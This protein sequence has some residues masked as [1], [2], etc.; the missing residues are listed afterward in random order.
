MEEEFNP[1]YAVP[2]D[3]VNDVASSESYENDSQIVE[4]AALSG[5]NTLTL[6]E[7]NATLGR[8]YSDKPTAL[9]AL[10]ETASYVGKLGKEVTELKSKVETPKVPEEFASQLAELT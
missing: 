1:S 10:K 8:N 6:E 4:Q 5:D 9:K 3:D 2:G 7:I